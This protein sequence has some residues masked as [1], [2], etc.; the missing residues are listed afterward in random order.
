M[1]MKMNVE[2]S[3]TNSL[4]CDHSALNSQYHTGQLCSIVFAMKDHYCRSLLRKV[5]L[6]LRCQR[7]MERTA[8]EQ[9]APA[10]VFVLLLI[11]VA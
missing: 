3:G 11:C 6:S 9:P 1:T 5:S 8:P 10:N 2:K 7:F 4:K